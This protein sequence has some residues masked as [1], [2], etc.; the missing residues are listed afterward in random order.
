MSKLTDWNRFKHNVKCQRDLTGDRGDATTGIVK[1]ISSERLTFG[2][3]IQI[4][5]I[6][7]TLQRNKI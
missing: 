6:L 4:V 3:T 7:L 5:D 1:I 2:L